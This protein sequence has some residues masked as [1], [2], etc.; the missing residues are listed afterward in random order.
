MSVIHSRFGAS[1][2]NC[3]LTR[4][5]L[6]CG[7]RVADRAAVASAPVEALD[8]GLAHQPGDPLEVHRQAQPERQ[9]GVHPRRTVGAARLVVDLSDLLEQQLVLL[10]SRRVESSQP[11]VIARPRHV[12]HPAG[13]RDIDVCRSSASSRTSGKTSLG[14][15]SHGRSTRPPASGSRLPS[16]VG[17]CP[18]AAR[19]APSSPCSSAASRCRDSS[20][21]AWAIQFRR[22]DSEIRSS[23]ANSATGLVFSRASSTA[24]RRNSGGWGA[25]TTTSFPVAAATSG[26]V[27]GL[28]GE[29]QAAWCAG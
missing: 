26:R 7:G 12:Q 3:R 21:S 9:L 17:A 13:H 8:P 4:S 14:E 18:G 6:G 10:A 20:T 15:R 22:H 29:A 1:T 11:L 27:S 16:P 24:R 19:R 23:F 25:G 2:V 28:R 5:A